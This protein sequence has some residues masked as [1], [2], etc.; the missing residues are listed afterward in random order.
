[1]TEYSSMVASPESP[2]PTSRLRHHAV[3]LDD[4]DRRILAALV[5]DARLPNNEIAARA[6]IAPSTCSLRVR[7]LV[8]TGVVTAFRAELDPTALGLPIQ[9][10]I[11][12]K[13]HPA[14][15]PGIGTVATRL[16]E[17]PGVQNVYFLAGG[18]DFMVQVAV[19]SPDALREFVSEHLSAS[20]EFAMTETS[21][22]FE[23][24]RGSGG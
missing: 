23:H 2:A 21:L 20:R 6:G 9:A 8:A 19:S 16:A 11:A 3:E 15:R 17:L 18:N 24:V 5:E 4:V 12:V 13:L 7:R 1:M 10:M 14:A 22:I